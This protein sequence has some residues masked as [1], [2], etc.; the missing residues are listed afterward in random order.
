MAEA[1]TSAESH[2]S[3]LVTVD[4]L[5]QRFSAHCF[6][7][8]GDGEAQGGFNFETLADGGYGA[9]TLRRWE[10]VWQNL[11]SETMPP[12]DM[13]HP[14]PAERADWIAWI[15]NDIFRL[16]PDHID[17]GQVVLR[18]LNRNE[19][20]TSIKQLTGVDLNVQEI[21]PADDTGYGFDTIG[22]V[23]SLS[24]VVLEKY[25]QAAQDVALQAIPLAGPSPPITNLPGWEWKVDHPEGDSF[26]QGLSFDRRRVVV[27]PVKIEQAGDYTIRIGTHLENAWTKTAQ[28]ADVRLYVLSNVA[29][30]TD[31]VLAQIDGD[32]PVSSGQIDFAGGADGGFEVTRHFEPGTVW[33]AVEF[34][35]T[36]S[37]ASAGQA[38]A[39]PVNY[40]FSLRDS[41]LVGPLAPEHWQYTQQQSL[42]LFNGAPPQQESSADRERRT[43]DVLRRFADR[44]F[45]RPIDQPTLDRLVT[46]ASQLSDE[47]GKRYEDGIAQAVKLILVSPRFLYRTEQ[48]RDP[49]LTGLAIPLDDYSLAT[50]LSFFLWGT[51][52]DDT[53]LQLAS[54]GRL[55]NELDSQIDR[56]LADEW[57]LRAGLSNFVGQWLQTRDVHEVAVDARHIMGIQSQGE[58]DQKFD[59]QVRQSMREETERLFEYLITANEPAERLLNARY[60]FLNKR[61]AEFYGIPGV[62]H[63]DLRRVELPADSHRRGVL[64]HGSVLLVTS[65]PTRTSPVKRGLFVLENLLGTPAPPA[66]PNVP[67]LE[68]SAEGVDMRTASLREIL[69]R[70]R[71]DEACASCHQRMDPLG[72]AMEN[73]NAIGQYRQFDFPPRYDGWWKED[74]VPTGPE[75]DGSGTL[76]TGESFSSVDELADILAV[77]RKLDFYRCLTEK[78]MTFAIGRGI[79][80][81]DATVIDQIVSQVQADDGR[82]QTLLRGIVHS[83][84]FTHTRG[85]EEQ[86]D[87]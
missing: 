52:P 85:R 4:Q 82:M 2:S 62:E 67:Q 38:D 42:I 25:I 22:E 69:E 86:I 23:L 31:E 28:A 7:C 64:T 48:A 16:S 56:M 32:E 81:R 46:V 27:H 15:Q 8:H 58:A 39:G 13:D 3:P 73:F 21:L 41:Q 51:P 79:T 53:L 77:D 29:K 61:L 72:L 36:S 19:Y 54:E 12:A 76:M 14:D 10:A 65:N 24:P 84:A 34:H 57:K 60:S 30:T 70:H 47:P 45:R 18:R 37:D 63:D 68:A 83:P 49:E 74:P 75:I 1:A 5:R 44:A 35:P 9:D 43:E 20:R 33:L 80:Y 71:R 6:D 26:H 40:Q 17:P 78:W 59:W 66:P 50:R 11:R 87:E 55:A